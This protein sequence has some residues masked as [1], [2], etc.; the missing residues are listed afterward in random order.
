M[1]EITQMVE[2]WGFPAA[3]ALWLM[4][5]V[6][7]DLREIRALLHKQVVLSA[8]IAKTLDIPEAVAATSLPPAPS[9]GEK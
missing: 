8:V 2:R 4:M 5:W 1:I 6:T 9:S 3:F 7:R